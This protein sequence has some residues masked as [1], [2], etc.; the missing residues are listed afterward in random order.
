M[1]NYF[2]RLFKLAEPWDIWGGVDAGFIISGDDDKD[3]FSLNLHAGAEY[4][5]N[6]MWGL[7]LEIGGGKTA[8]GGI[9][10]GIHF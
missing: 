2:D 5:F 8:S 4:K 3:D 1:C 9:G 10:V 7:I 6:D